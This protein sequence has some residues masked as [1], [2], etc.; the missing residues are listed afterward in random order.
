MFKR[1]CSTALIFGAAALAPPSADAQVTPCLPRGD[2]VE[3]LE[4][5]F[6]EHLVGGGLQSPQQ[7]LEVWASGETGSFTVFVTRPSGVS[8]VMAT[9]QHWHTAPPRRPEEVGG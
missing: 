8:C 7:L 6:D 9:G 1:L 5:Q 2:L 4:G 3:R